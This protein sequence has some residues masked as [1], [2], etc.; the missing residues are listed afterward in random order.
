MHVKIIENK[1]YRLKILCAVT[2]TG[3]KRYIFTYDDDY[4]GLIGVF[5]FLKKAFEKEKRNITIEFLETPIYPDELDSIIPEK[6][7]LS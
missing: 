7:F 6:I 4:N 5:D 3:D 1:E 2:N